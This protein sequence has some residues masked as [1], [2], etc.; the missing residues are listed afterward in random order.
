VVAFTTI[1]TKGHGTGHGKGKKIKCYNAG[2][3]DKCS[4][5]ALTML[6][7]TMMQ[8]AW[9]KKMAKMHYHPVADAR[10]HGPSY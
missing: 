10:S 7:M 9:R 2:S 6:R 1:G 4:M 3:R 5:T 8:M